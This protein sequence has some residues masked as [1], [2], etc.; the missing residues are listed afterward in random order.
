[1][2]AS[3][4][5]L[6]WSPEVREARSLDELLNRVAVSAFAPQMCLDMWFMPHPVWEQYHR[7]K[8]KAGQL[9]PDSAYLPH[10]AFCLIRHGLNGILFYAVPPRCH[11]HIPSNG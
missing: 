8:N 9:L 11:V 3:F 4:A 7:D 10:S 5:G 2:N 1:M 6:L